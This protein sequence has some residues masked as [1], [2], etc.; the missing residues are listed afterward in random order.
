[1]KIQSLFADKQSSNHPTLKLM[2]SFAAFLGLGL[3]LASCS[4]SKVTESD[5]IRTKLSQSTG[6]YCAIVTESGVRDI[7]VALNIA[8][9]K[10]C[11]GTKPFTTSHYTTPSRDPE[12]LYC[13]SLAQNLKKDSS[14]PTQKS[15]VTAP[16]ETPSKPVVPASGPTTEEKATNP[17]QSSIKKTVA[18]ASRRTPASTQKRK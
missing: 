10:N 13:C 1:M 17:P 14:S 6:L 3:T 18:P 16:S 12:V 7:S 5:Q 15:D 4:S 11:D 2:G 8:L 9:A